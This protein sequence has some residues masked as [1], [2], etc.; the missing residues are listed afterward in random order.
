MLLARIAGPHFSDFRPETSDKQTPSYML[1]LRNGFSWQRAVPAQSAR[2][3]P[4]SNDG[5]ETLWEP[6]RLLRKWLGGL[7]ACFCV[8]TAVALDSFH[9]LQTARQ[10][11][12]GKRRS[13]KQKK[14]DRGQ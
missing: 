2:I 7:V 10:C 12:I 5:S 8:G 11:R 14:S 3:T 1:S 9:V 13:V 6:H 4:F